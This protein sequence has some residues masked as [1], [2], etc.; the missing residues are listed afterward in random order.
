MN[1]D[2]IYSDSNPILSKPTRFNYDSCL[3]TKSTHNDL[4]T[5][6][7]QVKST[8]DIIHSDVHGPLTD[9]SLGEN[10]YFVMFIDKFS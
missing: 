4:K 5:L 10:K 2:N 8:F 6:Q 9:Q 7:D 1:N 3:Q